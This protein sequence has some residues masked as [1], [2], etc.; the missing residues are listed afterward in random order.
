MA[1]VVAVATWESVLAWAIVAA[2]FAVCVACI[3]LAL[4]NVGGRVW[5]AFRRK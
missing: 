4:F 5:D 2:L 3:G 1:C